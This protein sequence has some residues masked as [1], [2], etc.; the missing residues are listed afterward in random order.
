MNHKPE[1]QVWTSHRADCTF[2]MGFYRVHLPSGSV[3]YCQSQQDVQTVYTLLAHDPPIYVERDGYCLDG[4]RSGDANTP[5]VVDAEQW[6]AMPKAEAMTAVGL[7]DEAAY[8]RVYDQIEQAVSRRND[9]LSQG[10]VRASI[11]LKKRGRA[12]QEA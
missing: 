3:R 10:G 5:D 4:D 6:L 11:V 2:G 9:R 12:V 8:A 7:D 1:L